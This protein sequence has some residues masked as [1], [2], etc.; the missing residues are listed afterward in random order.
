MPV[1]GQFGCSLSWTAFEA[2]LDVFF[3]HLAD[4]FYIPLEGKYLCFYKSKV[5]VLWKKTIYP[6]SCTAVV[7]RDFKLTDFE[8]LLT[9]KIYSILF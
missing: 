4:E 8:S 9:G 5:T 6:Y 1:S 7:H 3:I 2:R